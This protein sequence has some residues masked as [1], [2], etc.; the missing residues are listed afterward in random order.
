MF[1]LAEGRTLKSIYAE[2]KIEG[3]ISSSYD[4]GFYKNVKKFYGTNPRTPGRLAAAAS[5]AW[6]PRHPSKLPPGAKVRK[7]LWDVVDFTIWL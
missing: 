7:K 5:L 1:A 6:C 4:G 3:R 2:L